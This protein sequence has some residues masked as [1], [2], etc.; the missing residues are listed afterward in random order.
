M[1]FDPHVNI[2]H[3]SRIHCAHDHPQQSPFESDCSAVDQKSNNFSHITTCAIEG[4]VAKGS[5]S[6]TRKA[7]VL[8]SS[9]ALQTSWICF[10]VAPN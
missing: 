8:G 3:Y 5:A 9:S 6:Q 1:G 7:V 4:S 10:T 2:D